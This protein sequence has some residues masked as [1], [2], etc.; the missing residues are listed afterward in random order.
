MARVIG[1][2]FGNWQAFVCSVV[3]MDEKTRAGGTIVS[4]N[5]RQKRAVL[6]VSMQ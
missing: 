4:M 2:D 5:M 1:L 6:W 3:G